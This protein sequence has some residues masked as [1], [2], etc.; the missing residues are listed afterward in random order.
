MSKANLASPFMP[1]FGQLISCLH[2]AVFH[3]VALPRQPSCPLRRFFRE[4]DDASASEEW[5]NVIDGRLALI[6]KH[7]GMVKT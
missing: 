3:G 5:L 1:A 6:E 4:A 7:T 2:H